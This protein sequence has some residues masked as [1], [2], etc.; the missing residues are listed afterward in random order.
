MNWSL[1]QPLFEL[2]CFMMT[3]IIWI[4]QLVHY[5]SFYYIDDKKTQEFH[6]FHQK[7]ITWIVLPL[8]VGELVLAVLFVWNHPRS[9]FWWFQ[10]LS[11][12]MI[13]LVTFFISVPLH[14][15][16]IGEESQQPGV[17]HRLVSTNW[18]RTVLWSLRS[19]VLIFTL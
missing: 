12:V 3:G 11:I 19:L 15:K 1:T 13:W 14:E 4:I 7:A 16:L 17:I 2:C 10:L 8:M 18:A 5:P 9:L 6:H